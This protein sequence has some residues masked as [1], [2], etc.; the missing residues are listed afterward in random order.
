MSRQSSTHAKPG[1]AP[2]L[3]RSNASML[4]RQGTL[5]THVCVQR[6]AV[7]ATTEAPAPSL[8]REVMESPGRP[9]D[10]TT[11]SAMEPRFG[12]DFSHVRVHTDEEAAESA[13][14]M[15]ANAY[16]AGEHVVFGE[17]K[18]TP[19]V[20]SG[21]GL[22][23]HELTHVV[24]QASGPVDG[25]PVADGLSVSHPSD[26]FEQAARRGDAGRVANGEVSDGASLRSSASAQAGP[27]MVQRDVNDTSGTGPF[28]REQAESGVASAVAG[29]VSALAGVLSAI[30]SVRSAN[31][32]ERSAKAAEDPPIPE[33]TTGGVTS[34]HVDIPEIKA[35]DKKSLKDKQ[36]ALAD[37]EKTEA[38]NAKAASTAP[39]KGSAG[40]GKSGAEQEKPKPEE[41]APE[42]DD[43]GDTTVTKETT[44]E[45]SKTKG[46]V[47]TTTKE[48]EKTVLKESD[49]TDHE[50]TFKV[51][52]LEQGKENS[53]EFLLTLRT[54]GKDIS[55]GT[56]EDGEIN[57]Y[58]GGSNESNASVGFRASAGEHLGD[59]AATVRLLYGG[60]NVSPR[61]KMTSGF[62]GGGGLQ[63]AGDYSFQRFSGSLK[64]TAKGDLQAPSMPRVTTSKGVATPKVDS[65]AD[66]TKPAVTIS[67]DPS[68]TAGVVKKEE[69]KK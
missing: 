64:F 60:T 7:G 26:R 52:R 55:G 44:K 13:R 56:T 33:P 12:F 30:E 38:D 34:T 3:T 43:V 14:A 28:Q 49:D 62:L 16:T 6:E 32:A 40:K 4:Q 66:A 39:K 61:K 58:L 41:K 8:V 20:P 37:Q 27:I 22:I 42:P 18:Y 35:L 24:Q 31:F 54:N 47:K 67:L 19:G 5:G 45:Q 57:G 2:G 48:T 23:A 21:E 29:G 15:N 9:L 50:K 10:S 63:A 1:A 68:G 46:G 53:A 59:G 51:L 69:T 65:S 25:T 11:R 36:K 17:G